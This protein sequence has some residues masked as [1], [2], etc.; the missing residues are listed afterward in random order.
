[1][2]RGT[3]LDLPAASAGG[4]D[5]GPAPL[6]AVRTQTFAPGVASEAASTAPGSLR[7]QLPPL[8]VGLAVFLV[9]L[10]ALAH[11]FTNAE[12]LGLSNKQTRS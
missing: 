12:G 1:M 4:F 9:A 11:A 6:P 3:G 2:A 5:L 10:M 7:R 8:V